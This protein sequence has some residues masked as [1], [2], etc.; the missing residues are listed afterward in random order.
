M[1]YR[2]TVTYVG[3]K[4]FKVTDKS[5]FNVNYATSITN[6]IFLVRKPKN[7]WIFLLAG[8]GPGLVVTQSL[9]YK[10]SWV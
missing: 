2:Y 5:K 10:R 4:T 7:L 1:R 6:I 3:Q 8:L 9:R